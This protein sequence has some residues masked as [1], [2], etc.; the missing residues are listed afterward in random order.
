M[1]ECLHLEKQIEEA[2]KFGQL[3]HL[4]KQLKEGSNKG[5]HSK[6][7]KK[8]ET[9]GKEKALEIF[10]VE[11][12]QRVTRQKVTQ[13]FCTNQEISFPLLT[14][15]DEQ[16]S[17]MVIEAEVGGHLIHHIM[18]AKAPS[19]LRTNEPTAEAGIKVAIHPKE[20]ISA[21]LLTKRDSQQMPIY[22]VSRALQAPKINYNSMEKLTF[23]LEAFDINYKPRTSICGKI[24]ADFIAE[25]PDK[26]GSPIE[27]PAKEEILEPWTLFTDGSSCLEGLGA[28]L[29]LPN[30]KG[31]EFT[32]ALRF[33]FN[34]S[35][36]EAE[37]ELLIAGLRI[38]KQIEKAKTLI[39]G[40]KK[41]SIEQVSR[42]EKKKAD[43][44]SKIK[45][46]SF[47]YLTKQVLV[48]VLKEKLIEEK[49]ILTVVEE[50]GYSWMTPLLEYLTDDTLPAETKKTRA[51][52][53]KSMQYAMIGDVLY[54]KSFLEPCLRY[55]G[56]LQEEHVM[57]EIHEGSY[58]M[59]SRPR[60]VV[61]KA[62]RSRYYWPTMHVTSYEN[63]RI[64]K[65]TARSSREGKILERG[66]RLLQALI[67]EAKSKAKMEK[68][69]NA[70]VRSTT[71]KP[72]DFMYDSNEASHA[73]QGGKWV[74]S[75]KDRT[76]WW[77]HLEKEHT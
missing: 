66:H 11:P 52:K 35:N 74:Q 25:R 53:I 41:F 70:K 5:E 64:D 49:E 33:E 21:V 36:N 7:A 62:I 8:G 56:P 15:N 65:Y 67:R 27:I 14:N 63:V 55:V 34:A 9:S 69:Y 28:G 31:M 16:E 37:Y 13:S 71:F 22:F 57:R 73:K 45:S 30:L 48:E 54:C 60:S 3:S 32:C 18:V 72:R 50:E 51:I 75:G 19:E 24:L 17:L 38:A 43:V 46:T 77:K 23:E 68:Y 76:K 26:D 29:I 59:H 61:T 1:D 44:L 20:A 2:V 10:M 58:N 39:S 40:F 47:A 42:S 6:A 12:W 4:I